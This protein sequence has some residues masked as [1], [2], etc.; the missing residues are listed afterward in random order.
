MAAQKHKKFWQKF[1]AFLY[2]YKPKNPTNQGSYLYWF[3]Q[4]I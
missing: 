2:A 1:F 4:I 3:F